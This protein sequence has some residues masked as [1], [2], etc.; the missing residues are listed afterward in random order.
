MKG[1]KIALACALLPCFSALADQGSYLVHR[2]AVGGVAAAYIEGKAFVNPA[3]L[4]L[5]SHKNNATERLTPAQ[6]SALDTVQTLTK[7]IEVRPHDTSGSAKD[8]NQLALTFNSRNSTDT[9]SYGNNLG[10]IKGH[11]TYTSVA[12]EP[13]ASNSIMSL[14]SFYQ[15]ED[16]AIELGDA[17]QSELGATNRFANAS[18][19]VVSLDEQSPLISSRVSDFGVAM[20]FPLSIVNMPIAVGVSPKLQRVDTYHSLGNAPHFDASAGELNGFDDRYRNDAIHFNVDVGIAMQPL[21][22]LTVEL[23]GRNLIDK[24]HDTIALNGQQLTY[25]VEPL[26]K[27]G[28][29]YDW[30]SLSVSTDI[31]LIENNQFKQLKGA[32]YWRLG[33]EMKAFDWMSVRVGYR[34]DMQD[35]GGDIYSLGSGF[36][37]GE[38]FSLDFTGMFGND[39][40]LGGVLRTSY[41]F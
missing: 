9:H 24:E 11:S 30:Q 7:S 32:Q 19:D 21:A 20:S 3:L 39:N 5:N 15:T 26:V 40:A 6:G 36:T 8:Y 37:I 23:S 4:A 16:T 31:D 35:A 2:A 41:H 14:T 38:S 34:H 13:V 33:G 22:G 28:V 18:V 12:L 29:A 25:Q 27:A 17:I 10:L 1:Y